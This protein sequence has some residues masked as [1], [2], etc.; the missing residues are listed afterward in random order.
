VDDQQQRYLATLD[1]EELYVRRGPRSGLFTIVAV[2]STVRGPSLGGCR[3]W[4]YDDNRAA[5]RDAL[6]LSEGMTYKSAVAG[7][8]LGGGKGVIVVKPGEPLDAKRRRAA[9]LD[10]GETVERLGGTYVTA[11]DVGTSTSDMTVI[12][13]AT[14]HVS[15]LSRRAGG[16]GDPSPYTALGVLHAIEAT[17][18]RAFGSP[19]LKGRSAAVVG[20]GHV[21]LPLA[22]LLAR[23]GA[24]LVVADIDPTKKAEAEKLGAKWT[25]PAKAMTAAVDV[26]VPCALGGVL[27]HESV[28]RLQA[29]AVA[30]AA[31]NQL[32]SADIADQLR[33]QGVLWAPDFVA[34]AGGIINIAVE[35]EPDGYDPARAKARTAEI[36][37]TLRAVYDR[38][39]AARTTPLS[40]AMA[41]A[42]SNLKG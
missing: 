27:D 33:E 38:A 14:S 41:L 12:A 7:L 11:E 42:E 40:A 37:A 31:N 15:G 39:A 16:S 35:L 26:L 5:I 1:H 9:L 21:G 28:P 2:H 34:N 17:V 20:L 25:T 22:R 19:S 23:A 10:F 13:K 18:E 4:T 30:G 29:P 6:R 8:P 3:M 36:G 24:K 32:A